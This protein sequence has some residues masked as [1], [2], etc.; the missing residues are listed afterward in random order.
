MHTERYC[1][2]LDHLSRIEA[3]RAIHQAHLQLGA[4]NANCKCGD[5]D[6]TPALAALAQCMKA[7]GHPGYEGVRRQGGN[8]GG[9]LLPSAGC[10]TYKDKPGKFGTFQ[11]RPLPDLNTHGLF[12]ASNSGDYAGQYGMIAM[13]PN[14]YSCDELAARIIA[15]WECGDTSRAMAQAQF[16][17]DCGGMLRSMGAIEFIAKGE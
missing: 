9:S 4:I 15:A 17:L 2:T 5:Y 13:H 16:I 10:M 11:T 6:N 3:I 8:I 1:E 7:A 14:G 12:Y